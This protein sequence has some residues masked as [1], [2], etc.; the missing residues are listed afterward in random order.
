MIKFFKHDIVNEAHS[1]TLKT[2]DVFD[3]VV[4]DLSKSS[5]LAVQA[6]NH[7]AAQASRHLEKS[8]AATDLLT[9]NENVIKK[10]QALTS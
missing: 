7:H 1:L 10:V 8:E 6:R 4:R 9:K 3:K 5:E 2:L